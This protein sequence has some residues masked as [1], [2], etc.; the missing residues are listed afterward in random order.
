MGVSTNCK[1]SNLYRDA[2]RASFVSSASDFALV[3]GYEDPVNVAARL[4]VENRE[5]AYSNFGAND[6]TYYWSLPS[7]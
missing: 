4:R 2:I 6:E 7:A 1:S 5:I 3:S